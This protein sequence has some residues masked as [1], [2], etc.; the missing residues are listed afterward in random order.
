MTSLFAHCTRTNVKYANFRN[1]N[2]RRVK[3]TSEPASVSPDDGDDHDVDD[4]EDGE[5]SVCGSFEIT[6]DSVI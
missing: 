1:A 4:G 2:F 5:A 6:D 3:S